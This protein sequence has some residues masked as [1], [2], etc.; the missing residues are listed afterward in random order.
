MTITAAQALDALDGPRAGDQRSPSAIIDV[1]S[2]AEF[3][4][5]H[6]P[7]AI[8]CP[9]LDN[10]QRIVVGTLYKQASPF[11]AKQVGAALVARN[12]AHHIE[13]RFRGQP[14]DWAPLVYCWRGGQRS[15]AMAHILRQ[16]G[17]NALTLEGGYRAYRR[18]LL[19][20]LDAL[21]SRF[22]FRVVSGVT[23]SAKSRLL[24]ALEARGAQVLD[25]E[26][27]AVHR[28]SVLGSVPG[29]PQP[30]Q[31]LFDTLVWDRLRRMDPAR[32]VWVEA[33]SKKVGNLQVPDALLAAM[34]ASPCL[35]IEAPLPERV[36]FLL[37]EYGHFLADAALLKDKL[38]H[39]VALHGADT[40]ARWEA[41]A[42]AGDW[43]ALVGE[44]LEKHY[45]PAYLKSSH[46]NYAGL[47]SA[48][49][50]VLDS[51]APEAISHAAAALP[52]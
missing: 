26:Q 27:I 38:R 13:T 21:P 12:I 10:E 19:A 22:R 6:V 37:D 48:Q 11:E 50:L 14:R 39:L 2:P 25:L 45:D 47:A 18:E 43:T 28:G 23:G 4:E 41:M 32:V 20:R 15:G 16:I 46:R 30:A 42:D 34:R 3:E 17:W 51:L 33:E 36:R 1:R 9:V 52:A 5:D 35:R 24:G 40:I 49:P 31:K 7:G 44:L 29:S 8:S